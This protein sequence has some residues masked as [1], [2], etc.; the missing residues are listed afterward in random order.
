MA[1]DDKI[2]ENAVSVQMLGSVNCRR[3][4]RGWRFGG[5]P[6]ERRGMGG[7]GGIGGVCGLPFLPHGSLHRQYSQVGIYCSYPPASLPSCLINNQIAATPFHR[8]A[9]LPT[10]RLQGNACLSKGPG[11]HSYQRRW[12]RSSGPSAGLAP[13]L[14]LEPS[15][16]RFEWCASRKTLD[17]RVPPRLSAL[18]C[19][20]LPAWGKRHC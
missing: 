14:H 16:E 11:R 5:T 8:T 7:I 9:F 4:R 20:S 13:P 18:L 1:Q 10:V 3:G 6:G 15:T 12:R 2:M 17:L 19:V